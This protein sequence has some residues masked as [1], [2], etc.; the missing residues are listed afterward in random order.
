MNIDVHCESGVIFERAYVIMYYERRRYEAGM[1]RHLLCMIISGG[2]NA[3]V[4]RR[5]TTSCTVVQ[6]CAA[7][8]LRKSIREKLIWIL[9]TASRFTVLPMRAKRAIRSEASVRWT[10]RVSFAASRMCS[11]I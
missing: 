11:S 6:L 8:F 10:S 3:W 5:W 2:W 4:E 7:A 9:L 1:T